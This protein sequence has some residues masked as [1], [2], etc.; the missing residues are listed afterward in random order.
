VLIASSVPAQD[1]KRRAGCAHSPPSIAL[2]LVVPKLVP[3]SEDSWDSTVGFRLA[4]R[5]RLGGVVEQQRSHGTVSHRTAARY[6]DPVL[7]FRILGTVETIKDLG[8][9]TAWSRAS[10]L[11]FRQ[12][13]A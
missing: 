12:C 4:C 7:A 10:Q 8:L 3:C 13:R 11:L 1:S 2:A 9:F 6:P 5:G